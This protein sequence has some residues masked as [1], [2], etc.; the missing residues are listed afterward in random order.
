MDARIRLT[1]NVLPNNM[2]WNQLNSLHLFLILYEKYSK[3]RNTMAKLILV[4]DVNRRE[5]LICKQYK[6]CDWIHLNDK[7]TL[8][9]VAYPFFYYLCV[10]G[11]REI[12]VIIFILY[13]INITR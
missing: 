7:E 4:S 1:C 6:H 3:I 5:Y 11:A 10:Y 8:P 13:T 9:F 2:I 12:V